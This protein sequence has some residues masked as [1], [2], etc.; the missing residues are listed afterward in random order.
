M[1]SV[2]KLHLTT[3]QAVETQLQCQQNRLE[4]PITAASALFATVQH[5]YN[6]QDLESPPLLHF[7]WQEHLLATTHQFAT[8]MHKVNRDLDQLQLGR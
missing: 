4:Q 3:I 6:T 2:Q 8:V 5:F 7:I 1:V